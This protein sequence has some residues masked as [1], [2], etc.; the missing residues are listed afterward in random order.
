MPIA[1]VATTTSVSPE[2]NLAASRCR[3]S[4]GLPLHGELGGDALHGPSREHDEGVPLA[5]VVRERERPA[6]VLQGGHALVFDDLARV[7]ALGREPLHDVPR[8]GGEA[9]MNLA[10]GNA[11]D[12]IRP[13]APAV[14]VREHLGFVYHR[15]VDGRREVRHLDRGGDVPGPLHGHLLLAGQERAGAAALVQALVLLVCE[16]SQGGEVAAR[17]GLA[18]GSYCVM[19]LA[20]VRRP[21]MEDEVPGHGAGDRE[22]VDRV[23]GDPVDDVA[24]HRRRTLPPLALL[25][26]D[27]LVSR[28][29]VDELAQA[30][31]REAGR[32]GPGHV[33]FRLGPMLQVLVR[34]QHGVMT[35]EQV[36]GKALDCMC[37]SAGL[38]LVIDVLRHA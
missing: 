3:T 24:L 11:Q 17:R 8:L 23:L 5:D 27:A 30:P 36:A 29:R 18:E 32:H 2:A 16:E 38:E 12:G 25:L 1:S 20:R 7:P 10:R 21:H 37:D 6:L 31:L 9:H 19:G 34:A 15:D 14:G 13:V 4:Y 35:A 28:V 26:Q 22:K 33:D